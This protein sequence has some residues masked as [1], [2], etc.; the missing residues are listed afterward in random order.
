MRTLNKKRPTI[1]DS[2]TRLIVIS[3]AVVIFI[4]SILLCLPFCSR[5]GRFT[6]FL[7]CLFTATSATCVT[8][9]VVFDTFQKWAPFGQAVILCLIQVGGLGLITITTFFTVVIGKKL[10]LRSMQLAQESINTTS[11]ADISH[12]L[13]M[14]GLVSLTVETAGALLL[15]VRFVPRFGPGGIWISVFLSI[16]AFCNAGFDLLGQNTPFTSLTEYSGDPY[17][18]LIISALIVTG[19]L[20]FVVW[21]DLYNYHKAKKFML[22]TKIVLIT[23]AVLITLGTVCFLLLEWHNPRTLGPF[24]APEK[25]LNAF[26]QSITCR[27]AGFNSIDNGRLSNLSKITSIVLMF[28]GAAPGS[29]GGGIKV[30]TFS[31]LI[32]TVIS[33][34]KGRNDTIIMKRKVPPQ[35]VNKSLAIVFIGLAAVILSTSVILITNGVTHGTTEIDALFESVSAFATVGLSSGVTSVASVASKIALI[36]TMFMGRVGPVSLALFI[37]VRNNS[38]PKNE[39]VPEGKIIVG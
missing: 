7:D 16:S 18:L 30:T 10:G 24:P 8:G 34:V 32:M 33:V 5:D 26:F 25:I 27:T 9:L 23:T 35:V 19:G 37:T 6:N 31:V 20:G 39:V 11:L 14:V 28:I 17:V 13:K 3:F 22:H 21:R 2:P 1:F 4:G 36:L 15:M 12:L 38:I 29:T